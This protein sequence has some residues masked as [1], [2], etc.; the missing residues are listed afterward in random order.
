MSALL[1]YSIG[2]KV[3]TD[4]YSQQ[5]NAFFTVIKKAF[6]PEENETPDVHYRIIEHFLSSRKSRMGIC[7]SRGLGKSRIIGN[8]TPIIIPLLGLGLGTRKKHNF[9]ILISA[10]FDNAVDMVQEIKDL[11]ESMAPAYKSLIK[12]DIWKSDEISFILA[13]GETLSIVAMGAEGKIRGIRRK[14]Y[15][16]DALIFD[17]SEYEELVLN[18]DRMRKWK[19]WVARSAIPAMT[20][21]GVVLWI[22]TPLP[23]SLLG[24]LQTNHLWDFIELPVEDENGVPAWIDRF[25]SSWIKEKKEEF[26]EMGE[27]NA[28]YQEFELK[29]ISEEEQI[30]KPELFRYIDSGGI[31]DDLDIYVTCD[32][33]ISSATSADRTTF[34]VTGVDVYNNI[35]VLEIFAKRCP[36]SEQ[37]EALLDICNRY[38]E[39]NKR[40]VVTVGMEKGALKHSFIDQWDR[41]MLHIGFPYKIPKIRDLDPHGVGGKNKRIQQLE[42]MFRT[43]TIVFI[44]GINN[45]GLM[46]EEFLSFPAGRHDDIIDALSYIL[47]IISWRE[48][49][50]AEPMRSVDYNFNGICW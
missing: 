38:Y 14:G 34:L 9:I 23:N 45:I 12:K 22:G 8:Y 33:A 16:P 32:L 18:P 36:P 21:D 29:I 4:L 31:P 5:T 25:P 47:Q 13:N 43:G 20:P 37:V 27:I 42:T 49:R 41:R 1:N 28:W 6:P 10:T 30:F 40:R 50:P 44:R 19:R 7:A 46:E 35:H 26:R 2:N 48:D 11:Y 17:D 24:E 3:N 39:R 15:R